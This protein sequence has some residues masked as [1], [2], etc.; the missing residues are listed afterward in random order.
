MPT[1]KPRINL[2]L[3]PERYELLRRL[4]VLQ[5]SSMASIIIEVMDSVYP[6]L[7][8]VVIVLEAAKNAKTSQKEGM[9]KA[10]ETAEEEMMP[11]M[12]EAISQFDMFMDEAAKATGA[13]LTALKSS[14]EFMR[15]IMSPEDQQTDGGRRGDATKERHTDAPQAVASPRI[16]NTGVRSEKPIKNKGPKK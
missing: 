9:R 7:E 16:C 6:V 13:D 5:E 4:A 10:V 12:Y 2:T 14:E 15:K 3:Q 11:H 8:R 1:K